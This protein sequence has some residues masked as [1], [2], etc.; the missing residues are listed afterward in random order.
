M[1]EVREETGIDVEILRLLW[2][3]EEID[4]SG[5]LRSHPYFLGIPVGGSL[6]VGGDPELEPE[7]Q[8]IDGVRYFGEDETLDLER[9]YPEIMRR[10]FWEQLRSGAIRLEREGHPTYRRR[11][12]DGFGR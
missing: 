4:S 11:P 2:L 12:C 9:V 6:R 10:E 7:A 1:R 8:V 5:A 3:V